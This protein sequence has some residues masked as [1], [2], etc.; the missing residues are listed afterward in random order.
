MIGSLFLDLSKA[1]DTIGHSILLEKLVRYGV[2]GAELTWF[3]DYLF[4]RSQQ[5]EI[6]S[7][8]SESDCP[9]SG[10]PQGWILGPL[11]FILLFNDLND[12]LLYTSPSPRD[13]TLSRMPSSA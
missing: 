1:F 4:N 5:V 3:T 9:T 10:V 12:C 11:M 13:A 8:T 6:Y 2:L 7:I